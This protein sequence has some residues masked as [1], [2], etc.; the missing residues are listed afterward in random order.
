MEQMEKEKRLRKIIIYGGFH[1]LGIPNSWLFF[2]NGKSCLSMDD[3]EVPLISG[4]LQ[5]VIVFQRPP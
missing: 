1:K 5:I 4:N 3:L 2:Y